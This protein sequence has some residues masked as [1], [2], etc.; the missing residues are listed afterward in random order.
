MLTPSRDDP[1][2]VLS[3]FAEAVRSGD[4]DRAK[5]YAA[6]IDPSQQGLLDQA[7][8]TIR[9]VAQFKAT[10]RKTFGDAAGDA[11]PPIFGPTTVPSDSR[12][13]MKDDRATVWIGTW[14]FPLVRVGQTWKLPS[15][16]TS[17]WVFPI[18]SIA[19]R[20]VVLT[21]AQATDLARRHNLA[22]SA[23]IDQMTRGDF[24]VGVPTHRVPLGTRPSSRPDRGDEAMAALQGR[25]IAAYD[26]AMANHAAKK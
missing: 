6:L 12:V 9:L 22:L 11:L 1:I 21:T 25:L 23:V 26:A 4:G 5:T 3:G 10:Y 13:E 7:A 24:T 8:Q 17:I 20:G 19:N 2:G 15:S 16:S 18:T 14:P